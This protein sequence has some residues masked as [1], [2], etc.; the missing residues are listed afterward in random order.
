MESAQALQYF[1]SET[2]Y[3]VQQLTLENAPQTL[4]SAIKLYLER[5]AVAD[6]QKAQEATPAPA[7]SSLQL[8][9]SFDVIN[10]PAAAPE[11]PADAA[12]APESAASSSSA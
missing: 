10:T 2:G 11:T 1:R 8:V 4:Q 7:E 6:D 3:E 9:E 5:Q 12:A